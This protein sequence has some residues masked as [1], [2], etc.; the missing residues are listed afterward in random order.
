MKAFILSAGKGE[1][2]YPLTKD[3]PK[4]LL[5]L[6][7]G[8]TVLDTQLHTIQRSNI[9]EVVIVV[10][11]KHEKIGDKVRCYRDKGMNITTIFNPFYDL[12]NAFVSL[13][14]CQNEMTEDF[15]IMNGDTLF[16]PEVLK[17]LIEA[18]EGIYVAIDKKE[19][20]G[21]GYVFFPE[22]FFCFL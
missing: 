12:S 20:Y 4:S 15:I 16:K 21:L 5:K 2:M 9:N 10:G 6:G 17:K 13:W 22:V 3:T 1:R 11:Y 7:N 8:S 18:G 19:K 14:L